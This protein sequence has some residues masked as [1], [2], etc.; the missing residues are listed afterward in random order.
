MS[1]FTCPLTPGASR[2]HTPHD[3]CGNECQSANCCHWIGMHT[4]DGEPWNPRCLRTNDGNWSPNARC[5]WLPSW[6]VESKH[7]SEWSDLHRPVILL[8]AHGVP[9]SQI[10]DQPKDKTSLDLYRWKC[11]TSREQRSNLDK[12]KSVM[13]LWFPDMT[14]YRHIA[15]SVQPGL[16]SKR[17]CYITKTIYFF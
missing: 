10:G 16:P 5:A 2:G 1:H 17:T 11:S 15:S 3:S 13:A 8:A 9:W 14:I 6:A 7:Q 12:K 4:H